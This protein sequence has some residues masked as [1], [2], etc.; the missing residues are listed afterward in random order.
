MPRINFADINAIS[1]FA[2]LPEGEYQCRLSDIE[3]DVTR[4]GDPMWKVRLTVESGEYAG[5]LLFD[6]L[7]FSPKALP[8]VKLVCQ[9]CGLDVSGEINLEP[10]DLLEKH[11]RV[12]TYVEE[13]TDDHGATKARN[14]IPWDG[15]GTL[16]GN[17]DGCPF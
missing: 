2:P 4:A 3:A 10:A 5:R 9:S 12:T 15:Y 1:D 16:A 13:Y 8:R 11:V 7:V 17:D 6:N 14:R